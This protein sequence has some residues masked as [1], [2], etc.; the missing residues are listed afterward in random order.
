WSSTTLVVVELEAEGRR[1]LGYTYASAAAARLARELLADAVRGLSPFDVRRVQSAC[2]AAVRNQGRGGVAAAAI[3]AVDIAAWDL[4]ARL[5]G[6]PL[7]RLLGMVRPEVPAY[8]SGGFTS[9]AEE[10]LC[11]QLS[12]WAGQGFTAVKMK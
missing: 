2:V 1:G 5:L 8:G 6:M 3:S 4:K 9:Y 10:Q 7:A 11:E 12:A